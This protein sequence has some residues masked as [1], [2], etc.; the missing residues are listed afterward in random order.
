MVRKSGKGVGDLC[1]RIETQPVVGRL[2]PSVAEP[3][4][5]FAFLTSN[6]SIR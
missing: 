4:L 5:V 3:R 1:G 6:Q 2:P